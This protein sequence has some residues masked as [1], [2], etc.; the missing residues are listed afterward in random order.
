ME[1]IESKYIPFNTAD[2]LE[3]HFDASIMLI[4]RIKETVGL[5]AHSEGEAKAELG[6][7]VSKSISVLIDGFTAAIRS[8]QQVHIK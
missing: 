6:E 4:E 8:I 7:S 3:F 1:N 2:E 5:M